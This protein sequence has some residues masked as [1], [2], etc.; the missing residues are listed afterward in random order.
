MVNTRRAF[1]NKLDCSILKS[2]IK[3][4]LGDFVHFLCEMYEV[5]YNHAMWVKYYH[6]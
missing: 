1:A 6:Y 2:E 5:A 3:S 4:H